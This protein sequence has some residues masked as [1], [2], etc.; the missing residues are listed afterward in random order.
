MLPISTDLH[1]T[2]IQ[3]GCSSIELYGATAERQKTRDK[4]R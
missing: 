1:D 2:D 3:Y 4:K